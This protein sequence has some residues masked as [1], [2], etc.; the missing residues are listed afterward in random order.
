[1]DTKK[2]QPRLSFKTGEALLEGLEPLRKGA[3]RASG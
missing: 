3:A 1:V 2:T